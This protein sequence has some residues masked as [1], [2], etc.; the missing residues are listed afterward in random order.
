MHM[1]D[2]P[3]C[4]TLS[5][6][7]NALASAPSLLQA[8]AQALQAQWQQ[9]MADAATAAELLLATERL[10]KIAAA[11]RQNDAAL[12]AQ[13]DAAEPQHW[14]DLP[15]LPCDPAKQRALGQQM[16]DALG[17]KLHKP[18]AVLR[19]NPGTLSRVT[20]EEILRHCSAQ[21]IPVDMEF[22]DSA[23]DT[24]LVNALQPAELDGLI[25]HRQARIAACNHNLRV[26]SE[27]DP[28][29]SDRRDAEKFR[30]Y[31]HESTEDFYKRLGRGELEW[32]LTYIPT[33]HEAKLDGQDYAQYLDFFFEACD[34]PWRA[35][36]KAQA[37]LIKPFNAAKE[38]HITNSDGTDIRMSLE[39]HT[40]A[41]SVVAHNIPGSEIFSGPVKE[42]LNGVIVAKGNFAID[43]LGK[44]RRMRDI[45][46]KFEHGRIVEGHAV[47]GDADL[48][49]VLQLEDQLEPGDPK[50]EGSRHVGE[51]GIGTNPHIRN[52]SVNGLLVEKIGGS[53]HVALGKCYGNEYLGEEVLMHN[54]NKSDIHWDLTTMLRGREGRMYLDG[55]L[56]QKDGEWVDCPAL[57]LRHKEVDVLNRGWAALPDH[58]QPKAWREKLAAAQ[59]KSR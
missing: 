39:G 10:A 15:N 31:D 40:F 45:T 34:Q 2:I 19:L 29:I 35:I 41:N 53:F 4:D 42:S 59:E 38:L 16:L 14:N 5:A 33:E 17:L 32:N 57:G 24:V 12:I 18:V 49:A 51:I 13:L 11:G 30:R 1:I 26:A 37:H 8:R 20:T 36:Q 27:I 54:G 43:I 44:T 7:L 9:P 52:H 56:V 23:F 25:A 22:I 28:E 3:L 21:S 46:L 47:E 55:H 6:S 58:Q 48:Q 50:F